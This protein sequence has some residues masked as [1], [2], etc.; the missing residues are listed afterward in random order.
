LLVGLLHL[1]VGHGLAGLAL[2]A[3]DGQQVVR[4]GVLLLVGGHF[5]PLTPTTSGPCPDVQV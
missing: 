3:V 5:P 4:H 1:L 2:D